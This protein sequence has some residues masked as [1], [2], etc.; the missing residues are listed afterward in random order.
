MENGPA[1]RRRKERVMDDERKYC[2]MRLTKHQYDIAMATLDHEKK[3]GCPTENKTLKPR[4]YKIITTSTL[5]SIADAVEYLLEK[6]WE[7]QGGV[8]YARNEFIQAMARSKE[9]PPVKETP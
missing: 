6:G 2:I 7:L 4:E 5:V 3:Y 8:S 1:F 9:K